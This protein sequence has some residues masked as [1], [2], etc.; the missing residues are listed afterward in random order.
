MAKESLDRYLKPCPKG[1]VLFQE[2]EPGD[3]MFV[4][5]TGRVQIIK[6]VGDVRFPLATLG[7]GDCI[8]EM[9]LLDGQPRSAEAIVTE[10]STLLVVEQG[11]FENLI[12]ENGEVAVR[13]MRKLSERLRE[14]NR[15]IEGFLAQNGT[16]S[17]IKLLRGL[18]APGTGFRA[19]P[20]DVSA[21]AIAAQAGMPLSEA[22][23]VWKGLKSAGVLVE[24]AGKLLLAPDGTLDDY[25][26]YLDLKQK[27]DPMTVRE[28][29]EATGLSEDEVHRVVRRVLTN[30]LPGGGGLVDSYQQFLALKRRFEYPDAPKA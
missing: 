23:V 16:L 15:T 6:R 29:A 18:A 12:R 13:I 10:D 1:T 2:G 11:T 22:E 21:H 28:L 4:I 19:L 5:Q 17:A 26:A 3:R 25:L 14:A 8:G 9:A 20:P 7:P 24:T 27:Y 30:R